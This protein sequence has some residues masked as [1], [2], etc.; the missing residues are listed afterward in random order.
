M[1]STPDVDTTTATK[2]PCAIGFCS[3]S[4]VGV[5]RFEQM[6]CLYFTLEFPKLGSV[7]TAQKVREGLKKYAL[8]TLSYE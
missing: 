5:D 2:K 3:H 8:K 4:S 1:H 7:T 6:A